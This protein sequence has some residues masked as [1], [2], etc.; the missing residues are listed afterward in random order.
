[1]PCSPI[2]DAFA[3]NDLVLVRVATS[4]YGLHLFGKVRLPESHGKAY[5]HFRT[6]VGGD[7]V[8]VHCIHT[9]EIE[10][11]GGNNTFKAIFSQNDPLEWFDT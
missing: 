3:A 7:M 9:E 11:V 1:M 5:F 6:F 4:A 10:D 8:K 2:A